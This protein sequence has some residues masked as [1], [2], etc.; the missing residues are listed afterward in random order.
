MGPLRRGAEMMWRAVRVLEHSC[1][2]FW[3]RRGMLSELDPQGRSELMSNIPSGFE[4]H[5]V[6]HEAVTSRWGAPW[7]ALFFWRILG[8]RLH[9]A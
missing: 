6:I 9:G 8:P 1:A 3:T 2:S 4:T 7:S 5:G